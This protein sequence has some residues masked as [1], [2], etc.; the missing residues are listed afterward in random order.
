MPQN[1]I[2]C[3]LHFNGNIF[4]DD[5]IGVV[6]QNTDTHILN[7]HRKSDLAHLTK[8]IEETL[9]QHVTSI[10]YRFPIVNPVDHNVTYNTTKIEDDEDVR[11]MLQCHSRFCSQQTMELYICF[12]QLQ[13]VYPTQSSQTHAYQQIQVSQQEEYVQAQHNEPIFPE[14]EV[15]DDTDS[16][17]ARQIN[18]FS[19]SSDESGDDDRLEA[20]LTPILDLYNPPYHLRNVSFECVEPNSV[21]EP[22]DDCDSREDLKVGMTFENKEACLH[23]ISEYHIKNS[24]TFK[25]LDFHL[26]PEVKGVCFCYTYD[27][28]DNT[29]E[30][31]FSSRCFLSSS[32]YNIRDSA[33]VSF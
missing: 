27:L 25:S 22:L 29:A 21:F 16:D 24:Y 30:S 31:L 1:H 18:L 6:F 5:N 9:Q 17:D 4:T 23:A 7:I 8:K 20:N 12:Q 2:S 19:G 14:E 26:Q 3:L 33:A 11:S 10:F 32:K 13:E 15:G 28:T